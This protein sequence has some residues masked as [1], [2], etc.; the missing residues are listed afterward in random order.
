MKTK[1]KMKTL[2]N[3]MFGSALL[4]GGL[5]LAACSADDV[6]P[7]ARRVAHLEA[8]EYLFPQPAPG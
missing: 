8:L 3:A 2:F 4:L 1:T 7:T 6:V 5:G